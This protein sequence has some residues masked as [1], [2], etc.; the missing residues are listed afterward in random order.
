MNFTLAELGLVDSQ[1]QPDYDNLTKLA[2]EIIG[3]PVSLVSIVDF[4]NDRQFFKSQ[5]G[6]SE[7]WSTEQQTPLSHSFCQHV[8]KTN[9]P[10]IVENALEHDL[11]KDNLAI[12]D[13]GVVSYLGVPIYTPD[14]QPTGALCA[15]DGKPRQWTEKEIELLKQLSICVTDTIK[16]KASLLTSEGLRQE[17]RD[18]T[19]AISHDLKS[20]A[21]TLHMLLDEIS[22][23][24]D[25]LS[26]KGQK[27][28]EISLNVVNRM[29]DQVED[30]L[31]YART[32]SNQE[33]HDLVDLNS[34]IDDVLDDLKSDI[35][36]KSA[37]INRTELPVVTGC[38]KQ[39][40]P[41]FQNLVSN[42][43]KFQADGNTPAIDIVAVSDPHNR[44]DIIKISDNGIGIP[45]E[46]QIR[47]F[48]LFE[49]LHT[50]E[51]YPGTGVGL[52]LCKRVISNHNGKLSLQSEPNVGTIF[53][54]KLP[55]KN[56]G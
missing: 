39:L 36:E 4:E 40:H 7:P 33:A 20:P 23:E 13:L 38:P 22:F 41:L 27:F 42:A 5:V 49:R 30:V 54:I 55:R 52:A 3:V 16:L 25:K 51:A 8:V 47:I 43:L 21:N 53:T 31:A 48:K 18:F 50:R 1:P 19:Y 15:I 29:K 24:Q 34:I 45:E 17:Q 14:A 37:L 32:G 28:L 46:F 35:I 12:R 10:L 44:Y 26:E 6:L 56:N 2:T 9:T 11:V